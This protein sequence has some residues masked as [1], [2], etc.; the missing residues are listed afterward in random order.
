ME[1]NEVYKVY[2]VFYRDPE[3]G[4]MLQDFY[5][6]EEA[7]KFVLKCAWAGQG[8]KIIECK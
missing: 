4:P 7:E 6:K 2:R 8:P 1:E 5:N 3:I